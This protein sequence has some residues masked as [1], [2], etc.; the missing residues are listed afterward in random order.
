MICPA[1]NHFACNF[2]PQSPICPN[3]FECNDQAE[4][5]W[6]CISV[7]VISGFRVHVQQ[8]RG[9]A[10]AFVAPMFWVKCDLP[11]CKGDTTV[12]KGHYCKC[13]LLTVSHRKLSRRH[14]ADSQNQFPG[15][16]NDYGKATRPTST[17][18]AVERRLFC[19]C[20]RICAVARE[21]SKV[22]CNCTAR[23]PSIC[24]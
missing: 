16:R 4:P 3:C 12:T 5:S 22:S 11:I 14:L 1:T 21:T 15:G 2:D 13:S 19:E 10:G 9:D 8:G 20:C 6:I 24:R 23:L 18:A 7:F 17:S